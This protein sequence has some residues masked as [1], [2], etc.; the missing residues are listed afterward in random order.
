MK[1]FLLAAGCGTRLR[2]LTDSIPK[3]MLPIAGTPLLFHWLRALAA[4]GVED[5]LLNTHHLATRVEA[6][7]AEWHEA[8]AVHLVHEPE[9]LG[10]GGTLSVN[11]Q[12][13]DGEQD[14]FVVYADNLTN[15]S[16]S[17]LLDAHRHSR[18]V[19]TTF[20][21]ETTRPQEKGICVLEPGSD[22]IVAFD[23]KPSRPRSNM[24]SAGIAVANRRIFEALPARLP[25]DLSREVLPALAGRMQA[26]RTDAYIR[27]IGTLEDYRA[28]QREWPLVGMAPA[29]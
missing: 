20:V 28:A 17:A 6:A 27:D 12:F 24:A 11:R 5:V 10:S 16:M 23:E 9:L 15:I 7:I 8:P 3:C 4:A 14:F 1:A 25:L 21:Y 29:T 2:P 26:V 18:M 22:R 19:F 13:V